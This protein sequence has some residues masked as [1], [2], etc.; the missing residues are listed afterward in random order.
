M[1]GFAVEGLIEAGITILQSVQPEANDPADLKRKFGDRL[2]FWGG[3]GSQ[4]T[5]SHGTALD[6]KAEVRHLIETVGAG[7]GYICSPAHFVEP[8]SPLENLDAFLEAIEEFG[9]Y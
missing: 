8:E 9:Y 4:S 3:V 1:I 5:M 6:V 2:A 7:G